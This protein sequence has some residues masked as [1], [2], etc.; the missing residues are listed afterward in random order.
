MDEGVE[1][2][3]DVFIDIGVPP[4]RV[5]QALTTEDGLA[6]WMGEGASIDLRPGGVAVLPDPVGGSTRR[7]RVDHIDEGRRLE[8]TWWPALRP[9]DRTRVTIT[10]TPTEQGSR[11]RVVERAAPRRPATAARA[12][13]SWSWRLAVLALCCSASRV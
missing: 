13:G 6:P 5:W 12:V 9:A 2:V 3:A 7:G 8:L 11:V 10:V 1:A 4:D